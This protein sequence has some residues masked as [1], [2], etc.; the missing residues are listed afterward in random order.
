MPPTVG[1]VKWMS[2]ESIRE[3][4]S[5]FKTDVWSFGVTM[6]EIMEDKEPY[7]DIH[8]RMV[9]VGVA[10]GR[11]RT[12]VSDI[13][14]KSPGLAQLILSCFK[15]RDLRPSMSDIYSTLEKTI[16]PQLMEEVKLPRVDAQNSDR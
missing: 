8:P 3:L 14:S 12:D 13:N 2:P 1:P 11:L 16:K 6:W 10:E 5:D 15:A 4:I 9:C 7:P